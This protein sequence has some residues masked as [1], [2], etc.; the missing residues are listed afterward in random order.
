MKKNILILTLLALVATAPAFAATE[1]PYTY[2]IRDGQ[3][4]IT[5]FDSSWSGSLIIT[6]ELGGCPVA[7]IGDI[8]FFA[9]MSL[10]SISIPDSVTN[11]GSQ[12]FIWC[13]ALTSVTLGKGVSHIGSEAFSENLS[14]ASIEV[15]SDNLHYVSRDNVLFNKTLTTIIQYPC[16]RSGAYTIPD[17]VT[18]IGKSS[19]FA[20]INL[21]AITIPDSVTTIE[22]SGFGYCRSLTSLTIPNSV[23]NIGMSAF[24][25]CS[26]LVSVTLPHA[27]TSLEANTFY[28][29]E[30]LTSITIPAGVTNIG[31]CAFWICDSLTAVYFDGDALATDN[32]AFFDSPATLYYLPGSSGWDATFSYR[33]TALWLPKITLSSHNPQN[34]KFTLSCFWSVGQPVAI[35][36]TTSL[37]NPQWQTI[38]A[39]TI[40]ASGTIDYE[41]PDSATHSSRFY[42]ILIRI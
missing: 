42:R 36:A 24:A 31:E 21:T 19:F 3:A 28:Q 9:C 8:A 35:Q 5:R 37:T 16:A 17:T 4:V 18:T 39:A 7:S 22:M 25:G 2:I 29:C 41:D 23:T 12:A 14:L 34:G 11:I 15:H 10:T 38:H 27:I 30:S 1:G 40:P 26:S 33:P 32:D 6:N 13:D 20:S